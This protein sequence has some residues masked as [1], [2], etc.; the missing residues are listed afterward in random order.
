MR[1]APAIVTDAPDTLDNL[2]PGQWVRYG[3]ALGRYM[4]RRNGCVWI[5][6]GRSASIRFP[7]FA[8]AFR[9]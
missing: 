8:A 6:W 5:A 1:Y 2:P 4:G 3:S 7:A 9:S